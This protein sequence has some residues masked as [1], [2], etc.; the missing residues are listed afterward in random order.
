MKGSS[1]SNTTCSPRQDTSGSAPKITMTI[2]TSVISRLP[3]TELLKNLRPITSTRVSHMMA[4]SA[5]ADIRP[6]D[7]RSSFSRD[8]SMG[9][10]LAGSTKNRRGRE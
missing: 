9:M 2:S 3:G 4:K 1:E 10:C 7:Q 5:T 6:V 8:L